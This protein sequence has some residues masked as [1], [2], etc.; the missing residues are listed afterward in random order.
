MRLRCDVASGEDIQSCGTVFP[1]NRV[2]DR[3]TTATP[4][5]LQQCD[6][7]FLNVTTTED[8]IIQ[9]LATTGDDDI[10]ATDNIL[11]MIMTAPRVVD[12]FD[13][14]IQKIGGKIFL[15]A[16]HGSAAD[17]LT[18]NETATEPPKAEDGINAP[19][20]LSREATRLNQN[21]SHQSIVP[22]TDPLVL[23]PAWPPAVEFLEENEGKK[24]VQI[25]RA[26]CRER[27]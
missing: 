6:R 20:P 17:F 22:D 19:V 21:F 18:V 16:R 3:A 11:A 4:V 27:V 1:L 12:S 24:L 8:P 2:V 7:T 23:G 14:I 26:S 5:A 9:E 15:D 25:G 10:F 13:V